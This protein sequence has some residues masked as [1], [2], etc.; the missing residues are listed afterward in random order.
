MNTVQRQAPPTA[1]TGQRV[2]AAE[3]VATLHMC[4]ILGAGEKQ[5][6][7]ANIFHCLI[8]GVVMQSCALSRCVSRKAFV[9]MRKP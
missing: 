3:H 2:E 8:G 9:R 5:Y 6:R 4:L 1:I 7:T